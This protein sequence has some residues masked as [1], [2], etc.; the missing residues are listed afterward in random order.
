MSNISRHAPPALCSEMAGYLRA[1]EI[2][3]KVTKFCLQFIGQITYIDNRYR[4]LSYVTTMD[5]IHHGFTKRDF[6]ANSRSNMGCY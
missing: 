1:K 3:K 2:S 4:L 5:G 6:N